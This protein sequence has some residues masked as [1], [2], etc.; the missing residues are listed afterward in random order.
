MEFY[1]IEK[2]GVKRCIYQN[3][4]EINEQFGKEMSQYVDGTR[5]LFWKEGDKNNR[6]IK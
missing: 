1:K 2:N 3:K 6:R 5:K 4:P